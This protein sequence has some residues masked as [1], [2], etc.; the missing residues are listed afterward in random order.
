MEA[1]GGSLEVQ[2]TSEINHEE[3]DISVRRKKGRI[4]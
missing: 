4:E 2:G 1:K 3:K